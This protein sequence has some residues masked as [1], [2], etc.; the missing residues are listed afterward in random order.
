MEP[1]NTFPEAPPYHLS[2]DGYDDIIA[3]EITEVSPDLV[4]LQL[5]EDTVEGC[6]GEVGRD[7]GA[8]GEQGP[9]FDWDSL[10]REDCRTEWRVPVATP[11]QG[12]ANGQTDEYRGMIVNSVAEEMYAT[13][14]IPEACFGNLELQFYPCDICEASFTDEQELERHVSDSHFLTGAKRK[15]RRGKAPSLIRKEG[16]ALGQ[17]PFRLGFSQPKMKK[18]HST[19]LQCAVCGR[20]FK[21][22][23][24]L[25]RHQ[26]YHTRGQ[27]PSNTA[28]AEKQRPVTTG[29]VNQCPKCGRTFKKRKMLDRHRRIY[30][31]ESAVLHR[32]LNHPDLLQNISPLRCCECD[33]HFSTKETFYRHQCFHLRKQLRVF[34]AS[35]KKSKGVNFF[36]CQLCALPFTGGLEFERHIK[37]THPEQ[38][39]KTTKCSAGK[40]RRRRSGALKDGGKTV[41]LESAEGGFPPQSVD[42]EE[43][44]AITERQDGETV[45]LTHPCPECGKS[46]KMQVMLNRHQQM[47]HNK[48]QTRLHKGNKSYAYQKCTKYEK[49]FHTGRM[50]QKHK[51]LHPRKNNLKCCECRRY[52]A[53]AETFYRH[54]CFHLRKQLRAFNASGRKSKGANFF[55]CQLCALQFTG[56]LEFEGHIKVTHP[57]QYKKAARNKC[58]AGETIKTRESRVVNNGKTFS[59]PSSVTK[60]H[61]KITRVKSEVGDK[62]AQTGNTSSSY[63]G[64]A[65]TEE[66]GPGTSGPLHQCP[67]CSRTFKVRKMLDKHQRIYHRDPSAVLHRGR[68]HPARSPLRCCECDRHFTTTESFYRH[69]CFHLRKQLRAF[70]ASGS[71]SKGANFFHCQL[72]ALQFTGGLDFERHIKVTHPEQDKKATRN[73]CSAGKTTKTEESRVGN[74]GKTFSTPSSVTKEHVKITRVKSEVVDKCA[75]I[76]NTSSSY[77]GAANTEEQDSRTSGPLHQCLKCSR[78][79]KVRKMLDKHQRIY[80]RDPSAVLHRGRRHPA[81][82]PLRCCECDRHFT[83]TESFYRHQCFHLRKQLRAF[84]ASGRKSK[85]ANFFH[86]QLCALQFTDGLE[87]ERHIQVT[88]PEQYKKATKN[89]CSAGDEHGKTEEKG[90]RDSYAQT[91]RDG[92]RAETLAG[93]GAGLDSVRSSGEKWNMTERP[94]SCS[95]CGKCFRRRYNLKRHQD[96]HT[97]VA[98]LHHCTECGRDFSRLEHLTRHQYVHTGDPSFTC[99]VCGQ[100]FRD[101]GRLRS[102]QKL[103]PELGTHGS[104]RSE[105]KFGQAVEL[106]VHRE[107]SH[108]GQDKLISS[109]CDKTFHKRQGL[110]SSKH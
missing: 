88:H 32:G 23:K 51:R 21:Q 92:C 24:S 90:H 25:Q 102:H 17:R 101:P 52:F 54:Q 69:Q 45:Q 94:F 98:K 103:H 42:P 53:A 74:N 19:P 104:S 81:R 47:Y 18:T 106:H 71:K 91:I 59:T 76:G 48:A 72:C 93:G 9:E 110:R 84:N 13:Y 27:G 12:L 44:T 35:D 10:Q 11:V 60:E 86:C 1:G 56:G 79:F 99:Q 63:S 14:T 4:V 105:E 58:S 62:C 34:N 28:S 6:A 85:G 108:L 64:A 97:R 67:K 95:H 77:S 66:Q 82:S 15:E 36:H 40:S 109:E 31:N 75:Q 55:H 43:R 33:R 65:K 107:E 26:W 3:V 49:T 29:T 2:P 46:F 5:K 41:S 22:L 70:N 7:E 30:H 96:A 73:K 78:T 61:V 50:L 37:V 38:Y 100:H 83:T 68:R 57:E 87:F 89:K 16:T 8:G 80:H 20:I 39:K